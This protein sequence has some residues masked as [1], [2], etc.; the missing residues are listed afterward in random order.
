MDRASAN[1]A[2]FSADPG[3]ETCDDDRDPFA[4]RTSLSRRA[5]HHVS[6]VAQ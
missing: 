2:D 6:P 4:R 1:G 5:D 3:D